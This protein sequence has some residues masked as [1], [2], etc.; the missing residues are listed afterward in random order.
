[1]PFVFDPTAVITAGAPIIVVAGAVIAIWTVLVV[2]AFIV[3]TR[4]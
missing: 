2:T 1:M 3:I 4:E